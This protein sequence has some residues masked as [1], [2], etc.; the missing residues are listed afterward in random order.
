MVHLSLPFPL[1]RSLFNTVL[2]LPILERA[3]HASLNYLLVVA[4]VVAVVA[5][6][7]SS[8]FLCLIFTHA[9]TSFNAMISR[10]DGAYFII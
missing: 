5:V 10:E 3:G 7:P 6:E 4:V 1:S 8:C 9:H 2:K